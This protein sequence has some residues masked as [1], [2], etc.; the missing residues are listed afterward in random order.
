QGSGALRRHTQDVRNPASLSRGRLVQLGGLEP[1]TSWSTAKRSNQLS[2]SCTRRGRGRNLGAR[3]CFDK[4]LRRAR[5]GRSRAGRRRSP[6]ISKKSPGGE[7]G[8]RSLRRPT[9][10]ANLGDFLEDLTQAFL[11]GFGRIRS[12]F[13]R[14]RGEFLGLSRQRLELLAGMRGGKF[15]D[16]RERLHR[17]QLAREVERG[18]GVRA[19]GLDHLETVVGGAL[20]RRCVGVLK[21]IGCLLGGRLHL[22]VG[23]LRLRDALLGD[24]AEGGGDFHFGNLEVGQFEFART[25][26]GAGPCLMDSGSVAAVLKT[27]NATAV[28]SND[29]VSL[30]VQCNRNIAPHNKSLRISSF[31]G[32]TLIYRRPLSG[33]APGPLWPYSCSRPG[34]WPAP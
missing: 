2:Y 13:L 33:A 16:F 12:H 34:P 10:T 1:P 4:V 24:F 5:P 29:I 32:E 6:P 17:H 14:D 31:S 15:D 18:V 8:L 25:C 19:R 21:H 26:P 23:F 20:R 27:A 30:L 11:D 22:V 28:W 3:S 7:P 9:A